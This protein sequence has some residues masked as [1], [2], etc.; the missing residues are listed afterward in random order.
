MCMTLPL[1][2]FGSY[3]TIGM[4]YEVTGDNMSCFAD[5]ESQAG[6]MTFRAFIVLV[7]V[8][9]AIYQQRHVQLTH[10][11]QKEIAKKQQTCL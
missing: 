11:L 8:Y 9:Y 10:Y 1:F 3:W 7:F 5:P 2:I 6:I 4:A